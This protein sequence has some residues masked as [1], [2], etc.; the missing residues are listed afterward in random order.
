LLFCLLISLLAP[1]QQAGT[2]LFMIDNLTGP[3]ATKKGILVDLRVT[4]SNVPEPGIASFQGELSYDKNIIRVTEL[5]LPPFP[6]NGTIVETNL[7]LLGRAR[8]AATI[9]AKGIPPVKEGTVLVLRAEC[10][11]NGTSALTLTVE[12]LADFDDHKVAFS[13]TQG[14]LQCKGGG[15]GPRALFSVSPASP[16]PGQ[17]V[18]F[19]D[20]STD[21]DEGGLAQWEWNF[22]DGT[23]SNEKNPEHTYTTR[24][25]YL[26][27]LK[28]TDDDDSLSDQTS[29]RLSVGEGCPDILLINFPN[30]AKS[31]TIFAFEYLKP[32]KQATLHVFNIKGKRVYENKT[33]TVTG[34]KGEQRWLLKD[35]SGQDLP[36]GPYFCSIVA[37]TPDNR[38]VKSPTVVLI[39]QR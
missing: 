26:V 8:F 10:L 27:S 18:Q 21:P 39:I 19:T 6:S 31:E 13:V 11:K 36:N 25:C 9:M 34:T 17:P 22:G 12:A 2:A 16:L 35:T 15:Q 29:K 30:P 3:R 14:A 5:K 37:V 28:V 7:S 33:L 32:I 4:L 20:Q 23:K 24:G 38:V 1:A